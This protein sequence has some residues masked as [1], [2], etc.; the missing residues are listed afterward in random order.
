MR[1][2]PKIGYVLLAATVVASLTAPTVLAAHARE[3]TATYVTGSFFLSIPDVNRFDFDSH[4][5]DVDVNVLIEDETGLDVAIQVTFSN[6]AGVD[7]GTTHHCNE[8]GPLDIP[9]GTTTVS[10]F[11]EDILESMDHCGSG[12]VGAVTGTITVQFNPA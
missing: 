2:I 3:E 11:A 4:A 5:G 10:V 12:S 6:A 8:S 7:L 9:D 1:P